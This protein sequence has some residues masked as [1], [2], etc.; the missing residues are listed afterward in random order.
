MSPDPIKEFNWSSETSAKT[1]Y[2]EWYSH[3]TRH[4][5]RQGVVFCLTELSTNLYRPIPPLPLLPNA[6][7]VD[8]REYASQNSKYLVE[9]R[10]FYKSFDKTIGILRTSLKYGC[11]ASEEVERN[12]LTPTAGI[13]PKHWTPDRQLR[14]ALLMLATSY[15]PSDSTDVS[16]LRNQLAELKDE[17][18]GGFYTYSESF[19]KTHVALV[20]A[21]HSPTQIELTE[22]ARKGLRN[23][24]IRHYMAMSLFILNQPSPT[25]EVIFASVRN[26]LKIL[27]ENCDPYMSAKAGPVSKPLVA[28]AASSK[29][30]IVPPRCTRCWRNGHKYPDCHAKTCYACG[31][32]DKK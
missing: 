11:K 26:F 7:V 21:G 23:D 2:H 14:A 3:L 30:T 28:G 22:W 12:L 20:K 17:M 10:D 4:S 9:M 32:D 5:S 31:G 27:G 15:A 24:S 18:E 8:Q 1:E 16:T 6:G 29:K 13:L 25:F 19:V